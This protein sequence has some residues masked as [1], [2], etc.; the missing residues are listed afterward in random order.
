MTTNLRNREQTT[1]PTFDKATKKSDS[2]IS[3]EENQWQEFNEFGT[4][5]TSYGIKDRALNS[6]AF[7]TEA[8]GLPS[9]VD[10]GVG[11]ELKWTHTPNE[12]SFELESTFTANNDQGSTGLS[13]CMWVGGTRYMIGLDGLEGTISYSSGG[14]RTEGYGTVPEGSWSKTKQTHQPNTL[15]PG[16]EQTIRVICQQMMI[17]V[18]IDNTEIKFLQRLPPIGQVTALGWIPESNTTICVTSL[19]CTII[20]RPDN[21]AILESLKGVWMPA[22]VRGLTRESSND[23]PVTIKR[24]PDA[25][26]GGLMNFKFPIDTE[27]EFKIEIKDDPLSVCH[28]ISILDA[29]EQVGIMVAEK[30]EEFD[31]DAFIHEEESCARKADADFPIVRRGKGDAEKRDYEILYHEDA[32]CCLARV[33]IKSAYAGSIQFQSKEQAWEEA[34][35]DPNCVGFAQINQHSKALK[36]AVAK[37]KVDWQSKD[38]EGDHDWAL[39]YH[40]PEVHKGTNWNEKWDRGPNSSEESPCWA[41]F[42]AV[43][44]YERPI[45][46]TAVLLIQK[47]VVDKMPCDEAVG[48]RNY[49]SY[50]YNDSRAIYAPSQQK[51]DYESGHTLT[52]AHKTTMKRQ[53]RL[54]AVE[55]QALI[56]DRSSKLKRSA[57]C[58]LT[59]ISKV[60]AQSEAMYINHRRCCRISTLFILMLLP[61]F[62]LLIASGTA[63]IETSANWDTTRGQLF[64]NTL[65]C[66][67]EIRPSDSSTSGKVHVCIC[68]LWN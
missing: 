59:E 23:Q 67:I 1:N 21:K 43:M 32:G 68:V 29:R 50:F 14:S 46:R 61:F 52:L 51:I 53:R 63:Y 64:I 31:E 66:D 47:P 34:L 8:Q 45:I 22:N 58:E 44:H 18:E 36:E 16:Q 11:Q 26:D 25:D 39:L 6:S 30:G 17:S 65:G 55:G 3:R 56:I 7:N 9:G 54:S 40:Q 15:K 37:E 27:R 33:N 19:S 38:W 20:M 4:R 10:C 42:Y 48:S 24:D 35:K 49:Q 41:H 13:F 60:A 62:A 28:I 5:R 57:S 2:P 12:A